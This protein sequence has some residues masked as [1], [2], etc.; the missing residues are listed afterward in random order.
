MATAKEIFITAFR[1]GSAF[2]TELGVEYWRGV[3]DALESVELSGDPD[4]VFKPCPYEAKE[5]ATVWE[6]GVDEGKQLWRLNNQ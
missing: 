5:K 4:D 6:I 1:D 3:F 2:A